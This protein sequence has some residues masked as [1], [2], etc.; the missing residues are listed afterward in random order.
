MTALLVLHL[1]L[2]GLEE[3]LEHFT[4]DQELL[5]TSSFI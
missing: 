2:V 3:R 1:L 4:T 5:W